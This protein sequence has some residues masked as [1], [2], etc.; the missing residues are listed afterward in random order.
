MDEI[1]PD[2]HDA[3]P[4]R[5]PVRPVVPGDAGRP[6]EVRYGSAVRVHGEH[7]RA[8][9]GRATGDRPA[10]SLKQDLRAVWR[11]LGP[12]IGEASRRRLDPLLAAAISIHAPDRAVAD[13]DDS[14]I[15]IERGCR[16]IRV[17]AAE[18]RLSATVRVHH[19]YLR[20][21]APS[22]ATLE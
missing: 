5:R 7:L 22:A 1:R 11:D 19:P 21:L 16:V 6:G 4:R 10:T 3:R 17:A 14:P 13:E 8:A 15:R 12:I 18:V 20:P 2:E 9:L